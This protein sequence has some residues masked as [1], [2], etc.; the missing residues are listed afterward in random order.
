MPCNSLAQKTSC[1]NH[2]CDRF[3]EGPL[4]SLLTDLLLIGGQIIREG[5]APGDGPFH[6]SCL[7]ILCAFFFF[8]PDVWRL[9]AF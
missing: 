9:S 7:P 2:P 5:V 4:G 3:I 6:L 8:L 1:S